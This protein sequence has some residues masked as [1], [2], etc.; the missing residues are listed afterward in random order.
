MERTN[1]GRMG[2]DV[3]RV[4]QRSDLP[5]KPIE[6]PRMRL[7]RLG[8]GKRDILLF[9]NIINRKCPFP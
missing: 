9:A 4:I 7:A 8:N 1:Q 5:V 6:A 2:R 3:E